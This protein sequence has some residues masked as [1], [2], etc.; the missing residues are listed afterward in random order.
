M[1]KPKSGELYVRELRITPP[2][3]N[4]ITDWLVNDEDFKVLL[5]C[6]EGGDDKKL[7][8]HIYCESTRSESWVKKWVYKVARCNNGESGN[9]V[10]FSRKPHEHTIGYVVKSGNVVCRHGITQ[11][12]LDEWISKSAEYKRNKERDRKRAQRSRMSILSDI[13]DA[14]AKGLHDGSVDRTPEGVSDELLKHYTVEQIYPLRTQHEMMV[15][16][17]IHPYCDNFVRSYYQKHLFSY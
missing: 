16:K 6:Q 17:L 3:Q 13:A 9:S 12:Y 11:T 7:H 10:Y 1:P 5:A 2:D 4:P 14:I 8:Y 15:I